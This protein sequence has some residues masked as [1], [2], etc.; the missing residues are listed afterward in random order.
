MPDIRT[1]VIRTPDQEHS[2]YKKKT[3]L[4][5]TVLI[6]PVIRTFY[7]VP[8]DV[9]ITRIHCTSFQNE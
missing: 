6:M 1:P 3:V 8:D 7:A 5:S 2:G 4:V 9:L